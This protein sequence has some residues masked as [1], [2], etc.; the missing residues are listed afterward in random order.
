MTDTKA[1]FSALIVV[2]VL[3]IAWWV[4]LGHPREKF[5]LDVAECTGKDTSQAAWDACAVTVRDGQK[6]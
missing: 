5:L 6:S 1:V 2:L 4:L 3:A